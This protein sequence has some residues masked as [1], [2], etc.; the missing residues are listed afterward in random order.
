MLRLVSTHWPHACFL[1][2]GLNSPPTAWSV[3][4]S[5]RQTKA[6]IA[7]NGEVGLGARDFGTTLGTLATEKSFERV[8]VS[9]DG[10]GRQKMI[11]SRA[12]FLVSHILF[13]FS[14][15]FLADTAGQQRSVT[16]PVGN[17][18]VSTSWRFVAISVSFNQ[19]YLALLTDDG[20]LWVGE[21]DFS[22]YHEWNLKEW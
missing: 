15:L 9:N 3:Y 21:L 18:G 17:A 6:L 5:E 7:F 13:S 10:S 4:Y 19:K 8:P 12:V 2:L 16:L 1:S 22:R 14:Q 20:V 11:Q